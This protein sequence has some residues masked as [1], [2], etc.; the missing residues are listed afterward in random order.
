[1]LRA[2]TNTAPVTRTSTPSP[3]S[4]AAATP[5]TE[6]EPI[7]LSP[8]TVTSGD[9]QS[10]RAQNTLAGSRLNSALKDTPGV[11]DGLFA[12]T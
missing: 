8:F 2:Q 3:T 10:C 1:L 9:D 4:A 5:A 11:L 6:E 7:E 12:S